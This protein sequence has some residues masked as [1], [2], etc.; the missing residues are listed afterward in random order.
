M[1]MKEIQA[2]CRAHNI[3]ARG[4]VRGAEFSLAGG[5]K[6]FAHSLEDV[7]HWEVTVA[8]EKL[9]CSPSDM[10]RLVSGKIS[11]DD[12][13]KAMARSARRGE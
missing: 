12:F 1:T 3:D 10:L 9:P 11:V 8:G 4:F 6:A 5:D 13:V 7:L 2:W